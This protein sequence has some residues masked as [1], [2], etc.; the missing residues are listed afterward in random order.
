MSQ[1][2]DSGWNA[3]TAASSGK[4]VCT[5]PDSSVA[6]EAVPT[7]ST[8]TGR[9]PKDSRWLIVSAGMVRVNIATAPGAR[10]LPSE[11]VATSVSACSPVEPAQSDTA[12]RLVKGLCPMNAPATGRVIGTALELRTL[13]VILIG[14]LGTA[15]AGVTAVRETAK[16]AAETVSLGLTVVGAVA[17]V[18][19]GTG[20]RIGNTVTATSEVASRT[21][22]AV[23]RHPRLVVILRL[24]TSRLPGA[25]MRP[26]LF[27]AH[28]RR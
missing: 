3:L 15:T 4:K 27:A 5:S 6:V 1:A 13:P 9:T 12:W 2:T 28:S 21:A 8:L 25:P 14:A 16:G 20:E 17:A 19:A 22:E 11:A 10:L 18:A 26:V 7:T 24:V 23:C